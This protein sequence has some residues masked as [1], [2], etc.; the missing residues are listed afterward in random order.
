M[1]KIIDIPSP[2]EDCKDAIRD[3][4]GACSDD[5]KKWQAAYNQEVGANNQLKSCERQCENMVEITPEEA[6]TITT[7]LN[8]CP[9]RDLG[10][11]LISLRCIIAKLKAEKG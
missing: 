4:Y 2:C 1:L 6:R 3:S 5:C 9:L 11:S 7:A 10:V 8:Y